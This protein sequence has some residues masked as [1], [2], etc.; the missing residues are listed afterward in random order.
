M[1]NYPQSVPA[2]H[3]AAL[4][5]HLSSISPACEEVLGRHRLSAQALSMPDAR[6]PREVMAMVLQ[7]LMV[8]TG[9]Q[10]LGFEMGFQTDLLRHPLMGRLLSQ[11]ST[12][13]AG[14]QRLAPYMPLLTP[15]FRM[16]CEFLGEAGDNDLLA[17]WHPVHPMPYEMAKIALETVLVSAHRTAR[18]LLPARQ[19]PMVAHVTWSPPPHAHRYQALDDLEMH[20]QSDQSAVG[21]WLRVPAHVHRLHMPSFN[22]SLWDHTREACMRQLQQI[23][24]MQDWRAWIE[25]L[26]QEVEDLQPSQEEIAGLMGTSVRT[27]ARHLETEGCTF[28]SLSNDIRVRRAREMLAE[29]DLSISEIARILGYSDSANFSRAFKRATG[30]PP[31]SHRQAS[32]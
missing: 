9:R 23:E 6:V 2:F 14:M 1:R 32:T 19:L 12:L 27:L 25:H 3:L 15:S 28:R 26:L 22:A 21:A 29:T 7:D 10:D 18:Q 31:Q 13:G 11:A 30:A 4:V 5:R 20:F 8:R 24:S 17:S 16:H